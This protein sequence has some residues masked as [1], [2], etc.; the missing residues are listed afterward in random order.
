VDPFGVVENDTLARLKTQVER[1]VATSL[2]VAK[3]RVYKAAGKNPSKAYDGWPSFE[4]VPRTAAQDQRLRQ[5][6]YFEE[7]FAE[8]QP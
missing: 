5:G 2:R 6:S 8:G 7:V 3:T 4:G 1:L